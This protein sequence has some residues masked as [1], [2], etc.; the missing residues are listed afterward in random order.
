MESTPP[1]STLVLLATRPEWCSQLAAWYFTEWPELYPRGLTDALAEAESCCHAERLNSTVVVTADDEPAAAASLLM[2]DV[3]PLPECSP[4][5]GT[6]VVA[7]RFRGL[8]L[9]KQVVRAAMAHAVQLDIAVLHLWT[10]EHR[11]FYEKLGWQFLRS[12]PA[13]G[14]SADLMSFDADTFDPPRKS[15]VGDR[16]GIW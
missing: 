11:M 12:V 6:V 9:G 4:W 3:L 10:P 2:A 13:P 7:P 16:G 15:G 5:L 1:V 8:G 14:G